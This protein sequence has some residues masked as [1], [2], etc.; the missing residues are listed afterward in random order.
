MSA[1]VPGAPAGA[2]A[3]GTAGAPAHGM[4]GAVDRARGARNSANAAGA[5]KTKAMSDAK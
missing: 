2:P 5:A 3:A 4:V 1:P